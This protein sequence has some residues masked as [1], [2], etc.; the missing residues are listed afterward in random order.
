MN[1]LRK[2]KFLIQLHG[3]LAQE[4]GTIP[5]IRYNAIDKQAKITVLKILQTQETIIK[6][7]CEH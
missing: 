3:L 6:T 4:N 5:T 1:Y 2:Y 7:L